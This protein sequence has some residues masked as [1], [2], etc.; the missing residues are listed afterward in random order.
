MKIALNYIYLSKNH[1]G[2]KDQVGL[3]LLKGFY[4]NGHTDKMYV[5]CFDYSINVIKEIAPDVNIISLKAPETKNE[6]QRMLLLC[7]TNTFVIPKLVKEYQIDIIYH[8]SCNTGLR[9][10]G[11]ISVVIPHDIKAVA[12]RI[13]ANVKIPFYKYYLYK[14][15]YYVDFKLNDYIIAISDVDKREISTFYPR[16]KNKIHRIYDPI[17]IEKKEKI[18]RNPGNYISAINLQF[19]HKNIITLIKAFELIMDEIDEDLVLIG[20]VPKRVEY[21]KEYV[22]EHGLEHRIKFTGFVSDEEKQRL[23]EESKLYVNP[24]LYEG[25]GMTAVE[26]IILGIPTLISKIDT[27]YEVTQ[28]LCDYY[29][30]PEDEKELAFMIVKCL[31]KEYDVISASKGSEQLYNA[32]NYLTISKEYMD[33]FERMC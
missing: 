33:F 19:H 21:L 8:L 3:N 28:G 18:E 16:F 15:M 22:K 24:T 27:N 32:Y 9:K 20:N 2:G 26:A 11:A 14:I 12:H 17:D 23:F 25:F 5:I 1:A 10:N 7:K 30:P 29:Y 4:E 13:L 31:K 6:L